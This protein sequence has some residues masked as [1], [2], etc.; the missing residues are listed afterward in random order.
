M[1]VSELSFAGAWLL[2]LL[3][4]LL[5]LTSWILNGS[6]VEVVVRSVD[7]VLGVFF[8]CIM[9]GR[10]GALEDLWTCRLRVLSCI[11]SYLGN[12][13]C[14]IEP[15]FFACSFFVTYNLPVDWKF[16]GNRVSDL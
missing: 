15:P 12:L 7:T 9:K 11:R 16:E 10:S 5:L 14:P 13:P 3:R 6:V 8:L 4:R 1:Y 2:V